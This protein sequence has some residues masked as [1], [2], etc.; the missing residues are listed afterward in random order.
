M[1]ATGCPWCLMSCHCQFP[2]KDLNLAL[3][4][5]KERITICFWGFLFYFGILIVFQES[6]EMLKGTVAATQPL[7]AILFMLTCDFFRLEKY[8]KAFISPLN[9]VSSFFALRLS[10]VQL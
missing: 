10:N 9:A 4:R 1:M 3:K 8:T 7:S 5:K 6:E 2:L